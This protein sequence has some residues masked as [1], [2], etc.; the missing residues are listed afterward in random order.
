MNEHMRPNKPPREMPSR[1][2]NSTSLS[3]SGSFLYEHSQH[4]KFQRTVLAQTG[5][6]AEPHRETRTAQ[7]PW[8][9]SDTAVWGGVW[10]P[11]VA[12]RYSEFW[13]PEVMCFGGGGGGEEVVKSSNY[14][15]LCPAFSE[16]QPQL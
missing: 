1:V 7:L 3:S 13:S 8:R 12:S 6:C 10:L 9:Q 2:G 4:A 5:S 11:K 14:V 16:C 15:G